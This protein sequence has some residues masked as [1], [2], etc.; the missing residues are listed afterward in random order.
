MK[1][2]TTKA[3]KHFNMENKQE[4]KENKAIETHHEYYMES[5]QKEAKK[6]YKAKLELLGL[7]ECPYEITEEK[8]LDD[9]T[10]WPELTYPHL[11]HYLIKTPSLYFCV[12]F[13]GYL[14]FYADQIQLLVL[15]A[16]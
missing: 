9:P 7:D 11:Y 1:E 2:A 5:L 13:F 4:D 10:Q 16:L 12:C 14:K 6:R 3:E 15:V 8:W